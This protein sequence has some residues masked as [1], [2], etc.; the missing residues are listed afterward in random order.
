MLCFGSAHSN[1]VTGVF[2]G[3][4]D[5]KRLRGKTVESRKF[6]VEVGRIRRRE[7]S[8]WSG[9]RVAFNTEDAECTENGKELGGIGSDHAKW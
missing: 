4:A 5:S 3:S 2:S 6:K 1:G 9:L 7:L 8:G